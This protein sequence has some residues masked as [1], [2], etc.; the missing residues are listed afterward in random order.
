M[1]R[2]QTADTWLA[3]QRQHTSTITGAVIAPADQ[4]DPAPR[5]PSRAEQDGTAKKGDPS[6]IGDYFHYAPTP[7]AQG[8]RP[9]AESKPVERAVE[10]RAR[11]ANRQLGHALDAW[12]YLRQVAAVLDLVGYT[13][14]GKPMSAPPPKADVP[15]MGLRQCCLMAQVCH[16]WADSILAQTADRLVQATSDVQ[17]EFVTTRMWA[18]DQ[19]LRST[20]RKVQPP[21]ATQP[22]LVH[23][24][25]CGELAK[26]RKLKR[27]PACYAAERRKTA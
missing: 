24:A 15:M 16:G 14:Y 21:P 10:A 6:D 12:S 27:C 22:E 18:V 26:Y 3:R 23:C 5:K 13:P 25:V 4:P 19:E 2:Q 1:N 17:V 20:A 7:K 9:V 11:Q 8:R